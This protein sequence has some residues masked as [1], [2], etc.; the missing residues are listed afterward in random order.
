M[1]KFVALLG[2]DQMWFNVE[3]QII[4]SRHDG[5]ERWIRPGDTLEPA[6]RRLFDYGFAVSVSDHRN[7]NA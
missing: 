5:L 2:Q 1:T 6:L 4:R 3:N 7:C